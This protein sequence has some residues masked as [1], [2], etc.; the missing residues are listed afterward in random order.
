ME[1][2]H[3]RA[4]KGAFVSTTPELH[5]GRCILAFKRTIERLSP[6]EHGFAISS[7]SYWAGFSRDIPVA[8]STLAYIILNSRSEEERVELEARCKEWTG[9]QIEVIS[10]DNFRHKPQQVQD[11]HMGI[12]H[13]WSA[14]SPRTSV[15][16]M[17][18]KTLLLRAKEAKLQDAIEQAE[19]HQESQLE[20]H[21]AHPQQ[22]PMLAMRFG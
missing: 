2:R 15:G 6:L 1:V 13:E 12:P 9:R 8:E 3:E 10:F 17:I 7:K 18:H 5:F 19:Q 21:A 14:P 11:L 4:F 22:A 20:H 16:V